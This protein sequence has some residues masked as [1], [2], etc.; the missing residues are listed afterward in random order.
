MCLKCSE[1]YNYNIT[2]GGCLSI[3]IGDT[4]YNSTK[5]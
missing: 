4:I 1:G 3:C 5:K 2:S